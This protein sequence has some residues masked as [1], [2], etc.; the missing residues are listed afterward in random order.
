MTAG[1]AIDGVVKRLAEAEAARIE[2]FAQD[3]WE[4][5]YIAS[6]SQQ[7]EPIKTAFR[8]HAERL[9]DLGYRKD[10]R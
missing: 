8:A 2:R 3:I 6:W 4:A 1:E 9:A 5:C 10:V 7:P